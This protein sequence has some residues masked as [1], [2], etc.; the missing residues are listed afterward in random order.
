MRVLISVSLYRSQNNRRSWPVFTAR[1]QVLSWGGGERGEV[2]WGGGGVGRRGGPLPPTR[3]RTWYPPHPA[4]SQE[5][6]R[7]RHPAPALPPARTRTGYPYP[8]P[9]LGGRCH[10]QDA[11]QAVRLLR[12]HAGVLSC[13]P[14]FFK[15]LLNALLVDYFR[16]LSAVNPPPCHVAGFYGIIGFY[17]ISETQ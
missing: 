10:G 11:E 13:F 9:R 16:K 17:R 14:L 12:F 5:Q 15:N 2:G 3:T 8:T 7:V 4:P 1:S 6:D